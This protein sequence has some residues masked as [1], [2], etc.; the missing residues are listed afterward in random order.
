VNCIRE[1]CEMIAFFVNGSILVDPLSLFELSLA[2]TDEIW[3]FGMQKK[4]F[5]GASLAA[6]SIKS[7]PKNRSPLA[8]YVRR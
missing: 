7:P 2:T 3:L 5:R 8:T 6:P 1:G 4:G